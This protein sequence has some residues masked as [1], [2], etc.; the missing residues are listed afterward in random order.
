MVRPEHLPKGDPCSWCKQPASN[1]R[2][3]HIPFGDPCVSCRLPAENHRIR[4]QVS[5]PRRKR[6]QIIPNLVVEKGPGKRF[7]TGNTDGVLYIGLDGE[8]IH[9][10]DHCYIYMGASSED[11]KT[12]WGLESPSWRPAWSEDAGQYISKVRGLDTVSC[13]EF[14]LDLPPKA[15]VFSY[16]FNYDLTKMLTDV[17][18]Q[19]LYRLF[20]PKLR[21][22]KADLKHLGPEPVLWGDYDLNLQGTK[23]TVRHPKTGRK[24]T[25][26]DI[27]KFYG[28]A[29]VQALKDWKVGNPE[30][31]KR[32]G[33]MKSKRDVLDTIDPDRITA[34]CLEECACM[35]QMA[36]KLDDA[37][38]EGLGVKLK[39]YYGAGSSATALLNKMGIRQEIV[40][41]RPEMAHA[42]SSAFFGGRFETSIVGAI[43]ER[44]Y[45][46]DISSAYPY[47]T[48]FLPCLGHGTWRLSQSRDEAKN[49]KAAL[50][51]YG[52]RKTKFAN[53]SWGPFPFREADGSIC[54][55]TVSGGGWVYKDEYFAG[56]KLFPKQVTF[57]EAWIYETGCVCRPF[58][59]VPAYYL[60]R[61]QI[62]K[63]GAG[64]TIKLA[65]NSIYGKLAQSVGN[66][67]FNCWVWAGMITSGCRAQA[68][69]TM[70]LHKDLSNLLMI[71]TDGI[72]TREKLVTPKPRDTNT[73]VTINDKG[74]DTQKPLGGWEEKVIDKGLFIA[75]SGVYLPL[76]PTEEEIKDV[77]GRG[78]GKKV[79]YDNWEKILNSYE[80][81]GLKEPV[82]VANVPRFCGAKTSISQSGPQGRYE[83]TRA[84]HRYGTQ[85]PSYGQW[86]MRTVELDFDQMPKRSGVNKDNTLVLRALSQKRESLPY[87]SAVRML[88]K[89]AKDLIRAEL[90]LS[91]QPT[92]DFHEDANEEIAQ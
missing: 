22:R 24:C 32:M 5:K 13:L 43:R 92:Y 56:E 18:N 47:Q 81:H 60:L 53:K 12:T 48:C 83:Y 68:L 35:A 23:F 87:R 1:H 77:R 51:H 3:S 71:A 85:L 42:V 16:A 67:P 55:P 46:Y 7:T 36:H 38:E 89:T 10:R 70:A 31:Y 62:G 44:V 78:I 33:G 30:L 2:V 34:Y 86:V 72:Y 84:S 54:F 37:H 80:K 73:W 79:L 69:E 74:V 59:S 57:K 4:E 26:W 27:F 90:E 41:P 8:G 75:R 6:N 50:I 28:V 61:I 91:E 11:G 14:V 64:L 20:R 66:A 40:Q 65:M 76:N 82:Q 88:N 19:K 63:E 58:A 17:D 21:P 39:A 49:A 15:R 9:R 45:N 25:V 52:M 29:F